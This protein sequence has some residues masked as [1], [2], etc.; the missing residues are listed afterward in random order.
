MCTSLQYRDANGAAY[1]GR[2]LELQME[3]P[4]QLVFVPAGVPFASQAEG[5]AAVAFTTKLATLAVVMPARVPTADAPLEPGDLKPLEGMNEA[6][7]TFSLLAYPSVG[8][9]QHVADRTKAVLSAVD[10]GSWALGQFSTVADVKAALEGLPVILEPLAMLGGEAPPV[11]FVLHDRTGASI[12]IEFE[13]GVGKV[14]DNPVGVMTNGPSF[15]WHLTNLAN[16]TFLSNIDQPKAQFGALEVQQPDSGIATAGLPA[17]NTSVGRFVRAAYYAQFA[18]KADTPDAA[19]VTLA[20]I[21]N[22][23][24]RPK[25]ITVDAASGGE[26]SALSRL[27]PNPSEFATE[28]TS[29]TNLS[30]MERGRFFLRTCAGLNYQM[31][32]LK[33]LKAQADGV[34]LM[35]LHQLELGAADA[36]ATLLAA[37]V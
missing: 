10:L 33:A 32:D 22:N 13:N 4:Y 31:I 5:T 17:S 24:D 11:H 14:H 15:D 36:T 3:L 2:T 12:V 23:F 35:P 26:S 18:E 1:L 30:D 28:Y 21:M 19:V 7:L 8:G 16:Y 27:N 6:G 29:W 25:G 20:H 34:R 37:K 9:A